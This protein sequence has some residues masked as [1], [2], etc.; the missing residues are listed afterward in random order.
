V[1]GGEIRH[2]RGPPAPG[3]QKEKTANPAAAAQA[4][5][6]FDVDIGVKRLKRIT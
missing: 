5:Q 3:G 2:R 1:G 4:W 6:N